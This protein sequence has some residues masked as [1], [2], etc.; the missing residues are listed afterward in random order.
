M[1]KTPVT[2]ET[3]QTRLTLTIQV[4]LFKR[5]VILGFVSISVFPVMRAMMSRVVDPQ[6][7]VSPIMNK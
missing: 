2:L 3:S 1:P 5:N 4:A 7:Q 6:E